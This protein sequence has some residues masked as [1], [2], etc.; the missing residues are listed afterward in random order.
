MP[1]LEAFFRDHPRLAIA[2]S[3][4][5]DSRFLC[6]CAQAFGCDVVA[7]HVHGPHIP[8]SDTAGARYFA[9]ALQLKLLEL[10]LD[11]LTL[12]EVARTDLRRCYFCKKFMLS[13]IRNLLVGCGEGERTI[14]DGSNHDDLSRYRPGLQAL[15]EEGILSPLALAGLGKREIRLRSREMGF[16]LPREQA[17]PCL[18][19]R[20]DYN[21]PIPRE[22]LLRIDKAEQA[23]QSLT[24]AQGKS[25]FADLRLR[26]TPQPILQVQTFPWERESEVRQVLKDFGFGNCTICQT[27]HISGFFDAKKPSSRKT[28]NEESASVSS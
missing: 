25:L 15:R 3:G 22:E 16:P 8:K 6:A 10:S 28:E 18:L 20:Y 21:L 7:V 12:P 1:A 24:D 2:F 17:R 26:I 4:G 14:C 19:T 23:L 13:G 9:R 27:E 11:P 5:L